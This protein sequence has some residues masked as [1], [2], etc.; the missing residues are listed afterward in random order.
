MQMGHSLRWFGAVLVC[1]C[2]LTG[3]LPAKEERGPSVDE[4]MEAGHWKRARAIAEARLRTSPDDAQAHAWLSK[5]RSS[6]G[7]TEGSL[8]EAERAVALDGR[9]P[10]F[11]G[12]LA[13]ACALMADKSTLL[14]GLGYVRRM[15]REIEAAL[16]LNPKHVDT[17]LV[18]MM[19]SWKAPV[20]AGGDKKR[21]NRVADEIVGVAP[22]WGYLAHARLLEGGD[23]DAT[24]EAMLQKAVQADPHFYRARSSLA[25]FY[26]C[27]ARRKRLDLAEQA[28][29]A[30]IDLDPSAEGGYEVLARVYASRQRWAD[31][32]EILSRSER[33]VPDDLVSYYGA[34]SVLIEIGQDFHRAEA[35]LNRYLGQAAEGRRPSHAEAHYLLA[36][37]Y[38]RENRKDDAV[39]ELLAAVRLEPGLESARRELKR[40]RQS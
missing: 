20:L 30:A 8:V 11:H 29:R 15:K 34:A 14:K 39:R 6:F 1:L 7:D 28:G 13:E 36:T 18:E 4:L 3:F 5:I 10:A 38:E 21:A 23:D 9:N 33:A 24:T 26:C 2:A 16:A 32:D 35:Y 25:T 12:Q 17:L 31:L 37:L 19:F 40:L 27:A 22:A